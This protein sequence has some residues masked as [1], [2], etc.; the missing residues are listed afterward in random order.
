M[1]RGFSRPGHDDE[2]LK[3]KLSIRVDSSEVF[4][5]VDLNTNNKKREGREGFSF[6]FVFFS[7][8]IMSVQRRLKFDAS[9]ASHRRVVLAM[10]ADAVASRSYATT[11]TGSGQSFRICFPFQ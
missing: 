7:S 1:L 2:K 10:A 3:H 6:D 8:Q 9:R 11:T 4:F 5:F